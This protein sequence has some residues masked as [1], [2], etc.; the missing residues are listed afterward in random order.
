MAYATI[1]AQIKTYLDTV[2]NIGNT[3]SYIR[4]NKDWPA[5][6]TLFKTTIGGTP[7][8]RFWDISRTKTLEVNKVSKENLR[9][10]TFRIRGFMSL[11]DANASETTFQNLIELVC[12]KFRNVPTLNGTAENI[13]PL[14]VAMVGHCM[15]GDVLCHQCEGY[16]EVEDAVTWQEN[17]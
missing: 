17:I 16:L 11:D 3:F 15:V 8:I 5:M 9:T 14:S 2:P 7:Q 13:S 6:L 12:A 10:Y 4:W 1:L